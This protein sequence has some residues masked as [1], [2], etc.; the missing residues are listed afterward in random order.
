VR[1]GAR[2]IGA[3]VE[4]IGEIAPP[5]FEVTTVADGHLLVI[6]G[7]GPRAGSS[8]TSSPGMFVRL[9]L[10]AS[11]R[12]RILFENVA[13]GVQEFFEQA[14]GQ[15]WPAAGASPQVRV[16]DTEVHVWYGD[17]DE[18]TAVVRLKSFHRTELGL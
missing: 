1:R 8:S 7:I 17:N 18:N 13:S 5:D 12:L 14:A 16:T 9:P 10:P 6:R 15:P 3:L 11:L 2:L 4:R